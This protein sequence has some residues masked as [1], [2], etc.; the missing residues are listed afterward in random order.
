LPQNSRL[1]RLL[2]L[3][4]GL[5]LPSLVL[6]DSP[7]TLPKGIESKL[8]ALLADPGFETPLPGG[9]AFDSIQI[10][11]DA[12]LVTLN[13]SGQA[14]ARLHL[15]P[16][17]LAKPGDATGASFAIE[18]ELL[19]ADP[20]AK[21]LVQRA[22][23]GIVQR[24]TEDLYGRFSLKPQL[25]VAFGGLLAWALALLIT[26]RGRVR[27]L[28]VTFTARPHHFLPAAIQLVFFA[29]WSLYWPPVRAHMLFDV[30]LQL[31]FGILFDALLALSLRRSWEAGFGVFPIV[32]S[33]NL[34]IWFP[35]EW[36]WLGFLVPALAIVSKWLF[37]RK[38]G[39]HVFNPSAFGIAIVGIL[40]V[41]QTGV[42]YQDIALNMQL[43][44]NMLELIF[45]LALIPI[46]RFGLGALSLSA[47]VAMLVILGLAP[48]ALRLPT[49]FWPAWF[50]SITLFAGD[51]MTT[52]RH[53]GGRV[54]H[55]LCLGAGVSGF[56]Y[57][58]VQLTGLDYFAKV[59]PVV[60]CNLAVPL[61]DRFGLW[62]DVHV[63][64]RSPKPPPPTGRPEWWLRTVPAVAWVLLF[65][66]A[67]TPERKA[68]IFEPQ[69][70]RELGALG[71]VVP[72]AGEGRCAQNAAWCQPF[73][74]AAEMGM[75]RE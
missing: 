66:L 54:L 8:I 43:P 55:G 29:Y 14:V 61:F 40:A 28:R 44:P 30:P 33:T 38:D 59:F 13:K 4:C 62:F 52:A 50:L 39:T 47:A 49:P 26:L 27:T 48:D 53:F 10:G 9:Y 73:G 32:L 68:A 7:P 41:T 5:L 57:L 17:E 65:L 45:L 67:R 1:L 24:D 22:V 56:A 63:L 46:V 11:Q 35:P 72:R 3:L 6:A 51:P 15:V 42:R 36:L 21:T 16:R 18:P 25:L 74:F 71:V 19:S 12:V 37:R 64:R 20:Q 58:L 75:V 34:F 69:V 2:L 60:V 23:A 31:A 70:F